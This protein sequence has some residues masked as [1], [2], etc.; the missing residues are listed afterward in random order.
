MSCHHYLYLV[1]IPLIST[2]LPLEPVRFVKK[3]EDV[4]HRLGEPLRL[5]CTYS[6]SQRVSVTWKKDDKLIWASYQYNVKTTESS[7]IL[8]VLN[9]DRAESAGKYTCQISNAEGTDT[10][11]AHVNIG[12]TVTNN[13]MNSS[14]P[15]LSVTNSNPNLCDYCG[16]DVCL[17][18]SGLCITASQVVSESEGFREEI[19][20]RVWSPEGMF[21]FC[22]LVKEKYFL[23]KK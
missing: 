12:N 23:V 18:C 16:E 22:H 19:F 15:M 14:Q 7:C 8:E 10:C 13:F 3:L 4:R 21:P 5:E 1:S 6:G 2:L 9:S 17:N 20:S 11:H